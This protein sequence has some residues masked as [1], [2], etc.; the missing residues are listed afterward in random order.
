[1]KKALIALSVAAG[2]IGAAQ[3]ENTTT[4]YGSLGVQTQYT[5]LN[6]VDGNNPWDLNTETAKL[7]VKGTEDLSN[8][9]QAFYKFEFSFED[10]RGLNRTRY[11]YIGLKG[12]FGTLTLGQQDSLYKVVTNYNDIFEDNFYNDW[13]THFQAAAGDSRIPKVISYVS[14]NFSGFQF[15]VAGVLDGSHDVVDPSNN[16]AF[17][18]AQVGAWYNA[19]GFYAGVAYSWVDTFAAPDSIDEDMSI[20]TAYSSGLSRVVGGAVGYSNDTFKAGFGVQHIDAKRSDGLRSYKATVY[21]AAGE[22]YLGD[23]TFRA[24][25]AM[26]NPQGENHFWTYAL[27]YQY[28]F[29]KRTYAWVEGQYSKRNSE[30]SARD[31]RQIGYAVKVGLRHDF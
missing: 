18:G 20:N 5:H 12:D 27:G 9:L 2:M 24:G 31:K 15:G 6:G 21:N 30:Y 25:V 7:G 26:L 14:P 1:M 17:T 4:L 11:A 22:Y 10:G 23:N 8:G 13:A 29:S 19:N 3:A 16:Q 28:N